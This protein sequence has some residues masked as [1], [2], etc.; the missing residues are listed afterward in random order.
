MVLNLKGGME[1]MKYARFVDPFLGNGEINL[2]EPTFPASTWH[3]IKGLTGNTTPAAALPFGKYSCCA[4]DGA[5]PTG[6]GINRVN[7][8]EAIGKIYEKPMFIGL[9]HFQQ[10]G[11]GAIGYYYN[12]ALCV[13]FAGDAPDFAPRDIEKETASS[14]YY[15]VKVKD[16]FCETTVSGCCA[17][18]R[19]RFDG[20]QGGV[21]VDFANDGLY[22]ERLRGK[23]CGKVSILNENTVAAEMQL[24]G[25][26]LH[27]YLTAQGATAEGLYLDGK[28][29]DGQEAEMKEAASDKRFGVLLKCA[30][31]CEIRLSVSAVS[32]EHAAAQAN[33]ETRSFEEIRADAERKW[34][35]ALSK[36]EIETDDAREQE[37]FYSNLYHTLVKPCDYT[38]E[39]FLF[40]DKGGEFVTD[41]ATMWDIYKTQLPLL[42]TLWPDVS[43]KFIKTM[44]RF[45]EG[46]G[47]YPHC[48]ILS[49]NTN[50]ESKQGRMLAEYSIY[51]AMVRGV[52]GDYEKLYQLAKADY[53]RFEDY[54]SE[55]CAYASHTLDMAEAFY[56]L[57]EM[58]KRLGHEADAALLMEHHARLKD[59]FGADGMMRADSDYY[60]GNR[61]NYSFRTLA[62]KEERVA[63]A[64]ADGEKKLHDEALRFFGYQNAENT[65]SRFEG[66][67]NETDMEAP[68]FLHDVGRRDLLCEVLVS[69]MES[70][71][72]TGTGGIPGNADSGGLTACYLW[73]VLG[74]WPVSGQDRM[75]VGTPRYKK[76]VLHLP[77]GEFTIERQGKGIYV[78]E[79]WL[80]GQKLDSFEFA[81][82]RMMQGGKLVTIHSETPV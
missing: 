35:E 46:Y 72:T 24:A 23:A 36:I 76:A 10:S 31:Q 28:A 74:V 64:G 32:R 41:I 73:N 3:F 65:E 48:L 26:T 55:G 60:E 9:A 67:N 66:F 13:P 70:M 45:A 38:G 7:S 69:G 79:A 39:A 63:L 5:Y 2:P 71:F 47:R 4:Y 1:F 75:I 54:F 14:G 12:H 52:E 25:I 51:D 68:Y 56:S 62:S 78:K 19:Y 27:F 37:I 11:T 57:A 6:H 21:F 82:S 43:R 22:E 15:S 20:A 49:G 34:E 59:A 80:D 42:F 53:G 18:H 29:L 30:E 50:I 81:A 44:Q 8:G 40:E 58:A 17:A 77:G 33:Q 16:I 61:Y